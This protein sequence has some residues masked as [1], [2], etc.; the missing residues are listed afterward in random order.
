MNVDQGKVGINSVEI[1]IDKEVNNGIINN[2]EVEIVNENKEVQVVNENIDQMDKQN[3][4]VV[5]NNMEP[6][7]YFVK[8]DLYK[9][10]EVKNVI[11]M[12]P[13]INEVIYD[14]KVYYVTRNNVIIFVNIDEK[15]VVILNLVKDHNMKVENLDSNMVNEV[16]IVNNN[17]V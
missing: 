11:N 12:E 9:D 10:N 6:N 14:V 16:K 4:N 1:I 7:D 17:L 2:I 5:V 8:V 13:I 15:V 3:Y